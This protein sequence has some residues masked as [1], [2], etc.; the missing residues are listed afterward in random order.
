MFDHDLKEHI[1]AQTNQYARTREGHSEDWVDLT[2][3]EFQSFLGTVML[4]EVT[5]LPNLHNYWSMNYHKVEAF[6]RNRF[7]RIENFKGTLF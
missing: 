6:P 5:R 4:M 2:V 1:V 7:M 3:S